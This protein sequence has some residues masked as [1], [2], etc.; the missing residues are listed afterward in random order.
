[1]A[2]RQ[3]ADPRDR[4]NSRPSEGLQRQTRPNENVKWV[5][6]KDMKTN[7]LGALAGVLPAMIFMAFFGVFVAAFVAGSTDSVL[8]AII[9]FL[10]VAVGIPLL[11]P[12]FAFINI[13]YGTIQY[14]AT[15]DR[16]IKYEETFTS[17]EVEST[18]I[19]RVRDAEYDEDFSDKLLGTGDIKIEGA[20]GDT[21]YF[22]DAPEADTLLRAVRQDI[23]ESETVD[24]RSQNQAAMGYGAPQGQQAQGRQPQGQ[25]GH[26][27]GQGNQQGGQ[28]Q[29]GHGQGQQGHGQ[30]QQGHGQGNQQGGQG[31]D[32]N[33]N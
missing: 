27:Q 18:P 24:N 28:G 4:L 11:S 23:A 30:G 19:N 20:R 17:T 10:V 2:Q 32:Y 25:Q 9:A 6:N 12:L 15:D 5:S 1:M 13:K 26:G 31:N 7:L 8:L 21:L 33:Q 22:N 3:Q 14:A 16:F 29:Q